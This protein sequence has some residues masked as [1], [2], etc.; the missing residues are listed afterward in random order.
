MRYI[1]QSIY[2]DKQ[3]NLNSFKNIVEIGGGYG[4][5]INVLSIISNEKYLYYCHD[6]PYMKILQRNFFWEA[7]TNIELLEKPPFSPD[8][9]I[10]NC[11][12][13]EL[14]LETKIDYILRVIS[15]AQRG[16]MI[17]NYDYAE[18]LEL[19][20]KYMPGYEFKEHGNDI[21]TFNFVP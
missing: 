16:F 14:D 21:V 17:I 7:G 1:L 15:K 8:L 18:N 12:W 13:S 19:L 3:F 2:I 10:A 11:S 6:L 5:L 9:L 4:G 20:K